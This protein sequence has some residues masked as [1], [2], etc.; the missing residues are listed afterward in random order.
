MK[1]PFLRE[2][3][4]GSCEASPFRKMI[5]R[6]VIQEDEQKCSSPAYVNCPAAKAQL[7]AHPGPPAPRC[8]FFRESLVQHCTA[9]SPTKF[10]P[11]NDDLL[12]RCNSDAHRYCQL[13]LQR[14][15]PEC[16]ERRSDGASKRPA[17]PAAQAIP[18]P[19]RLAYARN[20]M[21]LDVSEDGSCHVGVDAFLTRVLGAVERESFVSEKGFHRPA[22]VL[23]VGGVDLLLT[24][25]L[26]MN[27]T[28][29]NTLLRSKPERL[30]EDPYGAGWLF[31]GTAS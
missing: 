30:V 28:Q 18:L 8:P 6:S 12:S 22:V 20:H 2:T 24:F 31:E 1:C 7:Q 17:D 19:E 9:I 16:P 29:C 5:P 23:R 4:V 26:R 25:P 27:I 13:Y 11:Y 10:I 21:W 15:H 14:S 3:T